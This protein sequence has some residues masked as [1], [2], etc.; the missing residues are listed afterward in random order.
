MN[1]ADSTAVYFLP[2]RPDEPDEALATRLAAELDRYGWI[3][4]IVTA[5]DMVAIKTHFG[6]EG[7][8]GYVR[9]VC[10]RPIGERVRAA[11]GLPF[12]TDTQTLYNG[13]RKNAV[14]HLMLAGSHGFSLEATGIPLIMADGL[15]GDEE[16]TVPIAGKL[17]A[18]VAIASLIVKAQALVVVSHFTGHL[19]TG[20]GA[21]LKNM[22]MGCASRRGKLT[23]HSTAKPKI[24]A[25]KCARCGQCVRWCPEQ[26]IV[27][28]EKAA[29][30]DQG[31]CIGC[32]ECLAVCRFDAVGYNWGATYEELQRKVAEHALGVAQGKQGK[33]LCLNFL[34]RLSKD[35]DCMAGF[36]S[37]GPDIGVVIGT[38]PVAVDA[39]SLDLVESRL[40]RPLGEVAYDIPTR[41]QLE[42]AEAVGLG[43]QRYR[44]ETL[45]G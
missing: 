1:P 18:Q 32:G 35:C 40:G 26:A 38:D 15:L 6:E 39:A 29:R 33:L 10:F 43:S 14:E 13:K 41:V 44:L 7:T 4:Q 3:G 36:T 19:G 9:P 42:H 12:L 20:F 17:Y 34:T 8:T 31:K 2:S 27:L 45:G 24:K 5:H 22:G 21:A 28:E 11:G 16:V 30:I 23:Q 25:K 37:L